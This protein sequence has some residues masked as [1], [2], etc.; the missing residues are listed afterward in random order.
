MAA[1]W[2][3][4]R[5]RYLDGLTD[6][7]CCLLIEATLENIYYRNGAVQVLHRDGV[8]A[9]RLAAKLRP[10]VMTLKSMAGLMEISMQVSDE[11]TD[12]L[13]FLWGSL[14]I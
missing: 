13:W 6:E 5:A 10:M 8:K 9:R 7:E 2:E 11:I 4:V 14:R 12:S 3:D 1:E